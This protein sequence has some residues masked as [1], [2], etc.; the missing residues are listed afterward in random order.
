M[1]SNNAATQKG[2]ESME[3]G[4]LFLAVNILSIKI[5]KTNKINLLNKHEL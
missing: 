3:T 5:A 2:I 4:L 1:A